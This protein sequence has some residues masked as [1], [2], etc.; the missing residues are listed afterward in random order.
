MKAKKDSQ[1]FEPDITDRRDIISYFKDL[2]NI[3]PMLDI[4][5]EKEMYLFGKKLQ[6][7]GWSEEI[8][9]ELIG[10]AC[11]KS[12]YIKTLTPTPRHK[13]NW[14]EWLHIRARTK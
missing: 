2:L 3:G 4:D 11:S 9:S 6:E 8:I 14:I 5:W 7:A 1:V 12:I 10:I 13:G